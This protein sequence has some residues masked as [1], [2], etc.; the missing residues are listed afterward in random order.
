MPGRP[1]LL[2]SACLPGEAV[3]FD[4]RAAVAECR[5]GAHVDLIPVCPK[6]DAGLGMPRPSLQLVSPDGAIAATS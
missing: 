3:R 5:L 1:R 2:V 6:V 4:E